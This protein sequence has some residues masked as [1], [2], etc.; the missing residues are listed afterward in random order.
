MNAKTIANIVDLGI[1]FFLIL[2]LDWSFFSALIVSVLAGM[3]THKLLTR[4]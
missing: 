1:F 3:V 4:S 2:V